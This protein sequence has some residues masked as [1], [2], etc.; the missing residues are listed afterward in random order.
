MLINVNRTFGTLNS[1]DENVLAYLSKGFSLL[2]GCTRVVWGLLSDRF[3]FKTLYTIICIMQ[4]TVNFSIYFLAEYE[5]VY[6]SLN[7]L[8]ALAFAGNTALLPP[9]ASKIFGLK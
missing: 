5:A 6:F 4:I 8:T 9:L 3:E 2:N 1:L 7:M